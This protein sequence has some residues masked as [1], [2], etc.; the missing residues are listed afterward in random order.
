MRIFK[1]ILISLLGIIA[2]VLFIALFVPKEYNVE[3]EVIIKQPGKVVFDYIKLLKNQENYTVWSKMD[4]NMKRGFKGTD[5]TVGAVATWESQNKNVGTGEQEILAITEGKRID[6]ELRFL[7]PF[8]STNKA[9]MITDFVSPNETKV[10]WGFN[11]KMT[12]PMNVML[13][14]MNMEKMLGKDLQ[15]GLNN[16]KAV[17]EKE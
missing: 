3:R 10:K 13:L 12:Y 16:L 15:D 5:G 2:L 11:G 9:Y 4:A 14:F 6:Y 1:T 7:V 8:K 17:L